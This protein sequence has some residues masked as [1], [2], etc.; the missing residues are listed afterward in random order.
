MKLSLV[1]LSSGKWQGKS[2]PITMDEFVIGRGTDCHLRP[3]SKII[4]RKHCAIV[5]RG[6]RV[7]VLDF[8]GG[9]G[10]V[11]NGEPVAGEIEV[12]DGDLLTLGPLE[13]EV[14]VEAA[15]VLAPNSAGT[16]HATALSTQFEV[17]AL[18]SGAEHEQADQPKKERPA[19]DRKHTSSQAARLLLDRY[20]KRDK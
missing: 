12:G 20:M 15:T 8:G 16:A 13:F 18:Q 5:T 17:A 6:S 19:Q 9:E 1:V 14:K 10:T 11:V 3:V 7:F 4:G 2:L